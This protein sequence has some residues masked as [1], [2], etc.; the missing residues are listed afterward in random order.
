MHFDQLFNV[1]NV[2]IEVEISFY[3]DKYEKEYVL[4]G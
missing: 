1:E 4:R 3:L 2:G